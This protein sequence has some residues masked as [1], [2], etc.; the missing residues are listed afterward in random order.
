MVVPAFYEGF[1]WLRHAGGCTLM[2]PR[3][4]WSVIGQ[5]TA[6]PL[7]LFWHIFFY[8]SYLSCWTGR[9]NAQR[10]TPIIGYYLWSV[11]L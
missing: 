1:L 5:D 8:L 7:A 11:E 2:P 3:T 9:L 4:H 10:V 6:D